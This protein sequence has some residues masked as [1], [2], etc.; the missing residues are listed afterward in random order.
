ME[1][2]ACMLSAI[3]S[4][5]WDAKIAFSPFTSRF[6]TTIELEKHFISC[7]GCD[8]VTSRMSSQILDFL[9]H[10]PLGTPR[11]TPRS[12]CWCEAPSVPHCRHVGDLPMRMNPAATRNMFFLRTRTSK[13]IEDNLKHA[14]KALILQNPKGLH[15]FWNWLWPDAT[16]LWISPKDI[17]TCVHLPKSWYHTKY[18]LQ[19]FKVQS[20]N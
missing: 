7:S 11:N 19:A 18:C 14:V 1:G 15:R 2:P 20:N 5:S 6:E 4:S 13:T 3:I 16:H 8:S 17:Q 10:K 9:G 12:W